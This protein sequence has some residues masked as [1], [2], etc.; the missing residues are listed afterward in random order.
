M[1][2]PLCVLCTCAQFDHGDGSSS[3]S[4]ATGGLD[5]I[6]ADLGTR[7][8]SRAPGGAPAAGP[9]EGGAPKLVFGKK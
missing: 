3:R 6:F 2:T 8:G 5:G 1:L 9:A 4:S 7:F